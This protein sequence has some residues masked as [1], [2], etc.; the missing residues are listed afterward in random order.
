MSGKDKKDV[1]PQKPVEKKKIVPI[2]IVPAASQ[3][4]LTLYNAQQFLIDQKF[5]SSEEIRQKGEKKP[6]QLTITRDP[7]KHAISKFLV[8]DS[9]DTMKDKDW[10]R[11]VAVFTC[12]QEWQFKGWKWDKPVDIFSR[13]LGFSLKFQDEPPSGSLS[14]WN[15]KILDVILY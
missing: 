6:M 1:K 5:I 12:G 8:L 10:N 3:S 11:V 13:V 7:K 9:I 4:L 15:V 14:Q 2:I